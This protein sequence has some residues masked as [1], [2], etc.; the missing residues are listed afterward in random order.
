MTDLEQEIEMLQQ[1]KMLLLGLMAG[2][3]AYFFR[4]LMIGHQTTQGITSEDCE[5]TIVDALR[6]VIATQNRF[7]YD[8]L[9][10]IEA[11]LAKMTQTVPLLPYLQQLS[12]TQGD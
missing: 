11:A 7:G 10:E 1:E 9:A 12:E 6:R 3:Y 4:Q 2:G 5:R 8:Y